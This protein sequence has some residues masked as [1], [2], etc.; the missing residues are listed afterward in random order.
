MTSMF[1]NLIKLLLKIVEYYN[2]YPCIK[3]SWDKCSFYRKQNKLFT[4]NFKV[5]STFLIL[6]EIPTVVMLL[7]GGIELFD[8]LKIIHSLIFLFIN[9]INSRLLQKS[10]NNQ[11]KNNL[12]VQEE[13]RKKY[14]MYRLFQTIIFSISPLLE[15]SGSPEQIIESNSIHWTL[16]TITQILTCTWNSGELWASI[17]FM[18]I[19]NITYCILSWYKGYFTLLL[20]FRIAAPILIGF[21]FILFLDRYSREN[22]ILKRA[23]KTERNMY[24]K[25]LEMMQDPIVILDNQGSVFINSAANERMKITNANFY[26][27]FDVIRTTTRNISL[28]EKVKDQFTNC[29]QFVDAASREQYCVKSQTETRVFNVSLISTFVVDTKTVSILL[30]DITD[31]INNEQKRIAQKYN[32]V[33]HEF[34]TPLNIFKGFLHASKELCNNNVIMKNLRKDA[35]GAWS[36]LLNKINDILDYTQIMAGIFSIHIYEFSLRRF[37]RYLHKITNS[38]IVQKEGF[39]KTKFEVAENVPDKI[40]YDR[41]RL[42]QVLYNL[43]SNS[44]KFTNSGLI[45]LI[46]TSESPI[47]IKFEISDTGIGM[48]EEKLNSLFNLK[49]QNGT[50]KMEMY[51]K[52]ATELSGM[53]LT[54]AKLICEKM[55]SQITV[56]SVL[57]K[58]TIFSVRTKLIPIPSLTADFGIENIPETDDKICKKW[59][60][61]PTAS[62]KKVKKSNVVALVVDDN[63]SIIDFAKKILL[64]FKIQCFEAENGEESLNAL[65]S[66]ESMPMVEKIIVFMDLDMPIMD[67]LVATIEIRK[68]NLRVR[69]FIIA[70]TTITAESERQK[71]LSVGFDCFM[72]ERITKDALQD[73]LNKLNI[74]SQA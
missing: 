30:H 40:Q 38:L 1:S 10:L 32:T 74:D 48:S 37:I 61:I 28:T 41:E 20:S 14:L 15:K 55:N 70:L 43:L 17:S 72:P 44:A 33:S 66:I 34:K 16:L 42:E 8:I 45:S 18:S 50:E 69:P 60:G 65:E 22:F 68:R 67:G 27:N 23:Q 39:V 73:L 52:K 56:V 49:C 4:M 35:K 31:D 46:V 11:N 6:A 36:Y 53:G 29:S 64:K 13:I 2:S 58:G 7:W 51:N 19:F 24:R 47:E 9:Y 59:L 25:F 5:L 3:T 57:G 62:F 54:I 21:A 26:E 71:Y 12:L 63:G